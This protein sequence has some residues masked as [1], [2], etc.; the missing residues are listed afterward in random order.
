MFVSGG[1]PEQHKHYDNNN[2]IIFKHGYR[3]LDSGTRPEPGLHLPYYYARTVAHNCVTI[4]MPGETFNKH[5][6][7][8][9]S[10]EEPSLQHP[11]D[12]GQCKILASTL[13]EHQETEDYVYIASDATESYNADKADLVMR[14][15][16][17]CAPDVFVVFDRVTSDKAEYAK[18]WLYHTAAEPIMNGSLEFSE[19]SQ[20]GKSICR[21]LFPK[22]AVIEKIGGPGK[23]FWCDGRNWPLPVLTPDDY[24]YASRGNVPPDEWPLVGQWRVEV[25]PG[26]A[27]K[28]DYFMH[29]IQVGDESLSQLPATKTFETRAKIGVEFVYNGKKFRLSFD[30][31]KNYGCDIN[32]TSK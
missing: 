27:S 3:A 4:Y 18:S 31:T 1:I 26:K 6:G 9:A 5:W 21:T 16:I 7:T 8:P 19:T 32:V 20:G 11:N 30:K 29:I 28:A 17:W 15:F 13:L 23:Q 22:D 25:K 12:G 2:F 24:G 14:E 10:C